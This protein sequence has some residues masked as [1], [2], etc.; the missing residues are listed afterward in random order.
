[1]EADL[2]DSPAQSLQEVLIGTK[3]VTRLG[4]NLLLE[5][6]GVFYHGGVTEP[7]LA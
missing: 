4:E 7:F 1:M 6:S 5:H 2:H 3:D